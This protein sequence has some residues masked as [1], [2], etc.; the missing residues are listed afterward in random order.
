MPVY[1]TFVIY[2]ILPQK[3]GSCRIR[4][5]SDD[6]Q[7]TC[8][9]QTAVTE[10]NHWHDQHQP[11]TL[12]YTR[13]LSGGGCGGGVGVAPTLRAKLRPHLTGVVVGGTRRAAA[14]AVDD[15]VGTRSTWR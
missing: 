11:A 6:H 9:V 10:V 1:S 12:T 7:I 4:L 13:R 8:I 15:V 3:Y 2:F 5:S 14:M